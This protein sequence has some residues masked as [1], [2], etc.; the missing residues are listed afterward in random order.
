[1]DELH[2]LDP[3]ERD[4]LRRWGG[5]WRAPDELADRTLHA[6][7][8]RN[9]LRRSARQSRWLA[10]AWAASIAAVFVTGYV[11]GTGAAPDSTTPTPAATT[12]EAT[13]SPQYAFFLFESDDYRPAATPDAQKDRVR[14]Y[15]AWAR[16]KTGRFVAGEKLAKDG[17]WCRVREGRLEV[18]DPVADLVRGALAG[19][20]IVGASSYDEAVDLA[21]D[22]PHLRYGGS[23][24][25][26]RLE[27]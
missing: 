9:L 24:E 26:R 1:M 15:G 6:L 13:M 11:F 20:F 4:A 12:P 19:Y 7:R 10:A 22:C 23:I 8:A 2:E 14:E 18:L 16:A 5:R 17:R 21:K 25:V 3:V 27:S